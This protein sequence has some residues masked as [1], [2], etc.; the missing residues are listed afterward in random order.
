MYVD[1][2]MTLIQLGPTSPSL[3][4][5]SP[6]DNATQVRNCHS[7]GNGCQPHRRGETTKTF[8]REPRLC[9]MR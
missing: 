6:R 7:Q 4:D 5:T 8:G 9:E 2:I 1:T 3:D